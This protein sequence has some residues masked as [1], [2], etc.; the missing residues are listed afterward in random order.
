MLVQTLFASILSAFLL[1]VD[2]QYTI[3]DVALHDN[4]NDCWSVVQGVVYDV[5]EYGPRHPGGGA[6]VWRMCGIDS[7]DLY[8]R[9]HPL[10][11]MSIIPGIEN[12]GS[13]LVDAEEEEEETDVPT[14]PPTQRPTQQPTSSPTM[15]APTTVA[16]TTS[17]PRPTEAPTTPRPTE[18]PTQH[19]TVSW[20]LST[21]APTTASPTTARP[22]EALSTT[23]RPTEPPTQHIT[24]SWTLPT[25]APATA[26]PTTASPATASP[27]TASPTTASPTTASPTSSLTIFP[28]VQETISSSSAEPSLDYSSQSSNAGSDTNEPTIEQYG[29]YN[30]PDEEQETTGGPINEEDANTWVSTE[31]LQM[32]NIPEDCWISYYEDVYDVTVYAPTHKGASITMDCGGNGTAN[33]AMFHDRA[34]LVLIQQYYIGPLNILDQDA[35]AA[36]A[37]SDSDSDSDSVVQTTE[38]PIVTDNGMIQWRQ[39]QQ[40]DTEDDC[41]VSYYSEVYDMTEYADQHPPGP[42]TITANCGEDGTEQ[43]KIFHER[44][45]LALV[46]QYYIGELDTN[47]IT[48]GDSYSTS[49]PDPVPVAMKLDEVSLHNRAGDCYVIY[50]GEVYDLTYFRH[51]NPP[52]NE[53]IYADCGRDGTMYFASAHPP[54]LLDTIQ[55]YKVGWIDDVAYSAANRR[56]SRYGAVAAFLL[57]IM[58]WLSYQINY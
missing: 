24:V 35:S 14:L 30:D 5:T 18:A 8:K 29:S 20:T 39:L 12:L 57:S 26:S 17:R 42:G 32:H 40:H 58:M 22:T 3:Q 53:P 28:T 19:I 7:T 54:R 2:G 46:K 33:F 37:D 9:F 10:S 34:L 31:E 50:D 49:S 11:Y 44:S 45:M 55:D 13:V 38:A 27:T 16:P 15:M 25:K 1:Q 41:W 6:L 43:Y 52:G 48:N 36:D 21:K 56:G 47:S 23:S 4:A 51:P